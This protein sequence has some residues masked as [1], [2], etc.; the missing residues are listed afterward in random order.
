MA[1]QGGQAPDVAVL[2]AGF[3]ECGAFLDMKP[4]TML[5]VSDTSRPINHD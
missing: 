1:A 5:Q 3:A 4:E 2:R